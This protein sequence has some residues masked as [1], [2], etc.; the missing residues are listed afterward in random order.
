[1]RL[2]ILSILLITTLLINGCSIK[3][4]TTFDIEEIK[5]KK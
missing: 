2:I 5:D 3:K 4:A 1:M